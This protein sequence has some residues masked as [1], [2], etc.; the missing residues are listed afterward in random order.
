MTSLWALLK[1]F[2]TRHHRFIQGC[3]L[4]TLLIFLGLTFY[5]NWQEV[6]A[7]EIT[8]QGWACLGMALGMTILS[9]IWSGWVWGAILQD[10][11]QPI[12]L[13]WSIQVYLTTNLAQYLPSNVLHLYGRVLAAMKV[14]VPMGLASLSM[15]LDALLMVAAGVIWGLLSIPEGAVLAS[16]SALSLILVL[17]HPRILI[18]LM[19]KFLP[20]TRQETG[21]KQPLRRYPLWPLV[22]EIIYLFWRG[23]GFTLTVAALTPVSWQFIPILISASS[24]AW[25]LGFVTPGLPGGVG[26]VELTLITLLNNLPNLPPSLTMGVILSSVALHRLVVISAETLGA[27]LALLDQRLIIQFSPLSLLTLGQQWLVSRNKRANSS[28]RKRP[29]MGKSSSRR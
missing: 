2:T 8:A 7:I 1:R 20:R 13:A 16:L 22:G 17:L 23:L 10:L 24:V 27:G 19:W 29:L 14:G 18:R 11:N 21:S 15:M 4:V 5:R 26:V 12:S 28:G 25:L 6:A 9:Y 3:F